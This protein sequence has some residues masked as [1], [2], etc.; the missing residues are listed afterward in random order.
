MHVNKTFQ[1]HTLHS[2]NNYFGCREEEK[3]KIAS[4]IEKFYKGGTISGGYLRK[5]RK[6][7]VVGKENDVFY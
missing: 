3:S 1:C 6:S 4:G 7:L 5:D 2:R